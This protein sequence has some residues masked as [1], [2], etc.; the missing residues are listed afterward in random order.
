MQHNLSQMPPCQAQMATKCRSLC[1]SYQE[2]S[3][4]AV[5]PIGLYCSPSLEAPDTTQLMAVSRSHKSNTQLASQMIHL[6]GRLSGHQSPTNATPTQLS[7]PQDNV[8]SAMDSPHNQSTRGS[9]LPT[10]MSTAI[11]SQL[12]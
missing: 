5:V 9:T 11:Q 12:Q 6:K 1:S 3:N 4:P 7:Q 8:S 10:D 2:A